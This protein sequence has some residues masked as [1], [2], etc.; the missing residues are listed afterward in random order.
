MHVSN[1]IVMRA[2]VDRIY[3]LAARVERWPALLP[4]YRWVRVLE[5]NGNQRRV[6]MACWRNAIPLRWT[7]LQDLEPDVPRIRFEH[8]AGVT[9]GMAVAWEF[10]ADG[11]GVEVR[12]EHELTLGWPVAG[13]LV[14]DRVIG[15]YFV[16][17]VAGETLA[18]I[19][20]LAEAT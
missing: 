2:P 15:P 14:A 12:I 7:A 17:Y 13:R 3:T 19:K 9:R 1:A 10:H 5:A 18:R 8:I 6:E 11:D 16:Q 4:H 20:E